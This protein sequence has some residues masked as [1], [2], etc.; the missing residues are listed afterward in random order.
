LAK[1]VGIENLKDE[2]MDVPRIQLGV[3]ALSFLLIT[4]CHQVLLESIFFFEIHGFGVLEQSKN[5]HTQLTTYIFPCFC[6]IPVNYMDG[7]SSKEAHTE[8]Q[9]KKI[10]YS[11][12]A[13]K[14]L[15]ALSFLPCLIART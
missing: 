1:R 2:T 15:S 9:A 6:L 10:I 7:E 13:E 12:S 5:I 3:L 8:Y 14:F 4:Y 11:S